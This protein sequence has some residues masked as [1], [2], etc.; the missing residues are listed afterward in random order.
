MTGYDFEGH[1]E[2]IARWYDMILA[3]HYP[4][5]HDRQVKKNI[6]QERDI[7]AR[8]LSQPDAPIELVAAAVQW[9]RVLL[10]LAIAEEEAGRPGW[11]SEWDEVWEYYHDGNHPVLGP[12][13][14]EGP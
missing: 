14:P 4:E 1:M 12:Y 7:Y 3:E 9:N 2:A 5:G 6:L 8:R 13:G 10:H 11:R